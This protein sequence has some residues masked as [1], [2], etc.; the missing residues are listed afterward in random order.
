M[1]SLDLVG[2]VVL[3]K[4]ILKKIMKRTVLLSGLVSVGIVLTRGMSPI[5]LKAFRDFQTGNY[6]CNEW[7]GVS[8]PAKMADFC[9]DVI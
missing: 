2:L 9:G 3:T 1:S 5:D 6:L 8:V 7:S 4:Y